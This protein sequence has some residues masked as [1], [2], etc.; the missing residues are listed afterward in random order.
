MLFASY[1]RVDISSFIMFFEHVL[2]A[3]MRILEES[4]LIEADHYKGDLLC[5][6]LDLPDTFW[7]EHPDLKNYMI[8]IKREFEIMLDTIEDDIVPRLSSFDS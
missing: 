5:T 2:Q 4:P 1:V 7:Q 8:D 6:V 3:A